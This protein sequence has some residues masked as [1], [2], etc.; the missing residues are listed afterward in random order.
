MLQPPVPFGHEIA[1]TVEQAG[2][3][4]GFKPGDRVVALNSAPCGRCF[5]CRSAQ[6]NLCD[7]L[8]FNNGAFAELLHVPA[9]IAAKNT[10]RLPAD[11]PFEHAAMTEP[12]ACVVLGL[13]ETGARAGD[14]LAVIGAGPIGLLFI[15]TA[16]LAGLH[17]IAV[18]KHQE[19]AR[20]ARQFGAADTV[21]ISPGGDSPVDAVRALTENS[22]GVDI[23]IEAVASPTTWN[24]AVDMARKGGTVNFF[25]GPPAGTRVALD[26]NQL[27]Y[28]GLTLRASFHHTPHSVRR[29]FALLAGGTFRAGSFLTGRAP[30]AEVVA[31]YRAMAGNLNQTNTNRAPDSS[32]GI[33]TVILP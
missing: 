22:R 31:V 4:S 24:W 11:M 29:A 18:V 9:R 7:D 5:F 8:L 1:G 2:E 33:K 6:W 19:Q 20:R 14:T 15:H 10:L 32:T 26:T 30:L 28:S 25:G 23:A 13:E 12:L 3:G 17:V 21:L 16:A 27:H